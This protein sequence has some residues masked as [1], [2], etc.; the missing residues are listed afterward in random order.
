[1]DISRTSTVLHVVYTWIYKTARTCFALKLQNKEEEMMQQERK[2]IS[3][4]TRHEEFTRPAFETMSGEIFTMP[5]HYRKFNNA[6]LN[7]ST[8]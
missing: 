2:P 4:N 3:C 7:V 8:W 1:M 5:Y 6:K